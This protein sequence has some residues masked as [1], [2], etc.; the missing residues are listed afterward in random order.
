MACGAAGYLAG[1]P[2]MALG[3]V[4]SALISKWTGAD[5]T[6]PIAREINGDPWRI[7]LLLILAS[8]WAPI[9]EELMFRGSLFAHLRERWGWWPSALLVSL[10]FAI[11]HPQGL[12]A[13]P[14][15]GSIAMVLAGI[16]EWRGSILGCMTAHA[17]NNTLVL[18]TLV[19]MVA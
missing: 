3:L 14:A 16:R 7:V 1:L 12:A 15:L 9:T 8:V 5:P 2:I 6:H 11:I 10:V 17:I 18:M 13:L 19:L 4:A